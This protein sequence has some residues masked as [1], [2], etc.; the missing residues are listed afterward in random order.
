MRLDFD[1]AGTDGMIL[2][3]MV[4]DVKEVAERLCLPCPNICSGFGYPEWSSMTLHQFC[5]ISLIS[6]LARL[7]LRKYPGLRTE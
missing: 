4:R 2:Q 5:R 6:Q 3:G 1:G 7:C